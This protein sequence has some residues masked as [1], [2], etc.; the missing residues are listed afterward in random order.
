[1]THEDTTIQAIAIGLQNLSVDGLCTI[2]AY[3]GTERG[4]RES[5][6]VEAYLSSIDQTV[7]HSS[8]WHPINQKHNPPILYIIRRRK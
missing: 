8:T 5:K 6:A 1:M 4:F 2:V 7:Y 3:P